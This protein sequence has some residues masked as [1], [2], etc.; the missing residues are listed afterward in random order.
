MWLKLIKAQSQI[1]PD[2][3]GYVIGNFEE[4]MGGGSL[5][6]HDSLGDAFTGEMGHLVHKVEILH[7]ERTTWSDRK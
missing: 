1:Q 7:E 5:G 6:V 3:L 2:L 4:T